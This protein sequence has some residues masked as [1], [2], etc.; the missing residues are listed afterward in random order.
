V[1]NGNKRIYPEKVLDESMN[2]YI[3]DYVSKSRAVGELIHPMCYASGA[4]VVTHNKGIIPIEDVVIGDTVY[5]VDESG[6][7]VITPVIGTVN[8]SYSGDMIR[9]KSRSIHALVTPNHRFYLQTRYKGLVVKT[10]E[11]IHSSINGDN[12]LSHEYIPQYIQNYDSPDIEDIIIPGIL[13]SRHKKYHQDLI[14]NFDLYSKLMGIYL[15]EGYVTYS[16]KKT[17]CSVNICQNINTNLDLIID[18]VSDIGLKSTVYVKDDNRAIVSITDNRLAK[19]FSQFGKNCYTKEVPIEIRQASKNQISEFLEWYVLGDGSLLNIQHTTLSGENKIYTY[20]NLFT[21]SINLIRGLEECLLKCGYSVNERIQL[22]PE[23]YTF[24]GRTI[25]IKNKSPL[26]RVN[27]GKRRGAYTFNRHM[28]STKEFYEG[29][30]HCLT[31]ETGN[32][33]VMY[34]GYSHLTGNSSAIGLDRVSHLITEMRKD[35]KNYIGKARILNTPTGKIAQ[36]LLEGG[37]KLGVS[38]RADGKVV[39]NARGLNEVAP[40]LGMKAIDIVFNPSAPD[41][42]VDSIMESVDT[43]MDALSEDMMLVESIRSD[44]RGANLHSLQE[45]KLKAF[46]QIMRHLSIK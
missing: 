40:G 10:A 4:L 41:A 7:S 27:F 13:N 12:K 14:L 25:Q 16:N 1:V 20:K 6:N 5:G 29:T 42:L 43:V 28:K 8:E 21:T 46:T 36:A 33:Y 17:P 22:S 34:D 39:Q 15:A 24:A 30:V 18:L 32:F 3:K 2:A 9:L 38:T 37:V 11:E 19:Y 44:I 35:G 31:T 45:A 26:Y 23:D